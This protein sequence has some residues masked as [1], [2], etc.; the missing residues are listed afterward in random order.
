MLISINF[1]LKT[2]NP[3]AFKNG[4]LCFPGSFL[5]ENGSVSPNSHMG[6]WNLGSSLLLFPFKMHVSPKKIVSFSTKRK[7]SFP[8]EPLRNG[9]KGGEKNSFEMVVFL[10]RTPNLPFSPFA[11]NGI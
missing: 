3:V 6:R 9:E 1:T 10:T 2:S 4:T 7:G 8:T 11:K 5:F